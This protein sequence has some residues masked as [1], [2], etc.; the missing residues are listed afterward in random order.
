[1]E[2]FAELVEK[3]KQFAAQPIVLENAPLKADDLPMLVL[4]RRVANQ[5]AAIDCFLKQQDVEIA[6]RLPLRAVLEA[7]ADLNRAK[8]SALLKPVPTKAR[9]KASN[10][11]DPEHW[12]ILC[13]LVCA[14][15]RAYM[16]DGKN[17]PAAA[18]L[19]ARALERHGIGDP[20]G[21]PLD[22]KTIGRWDERSDLK[23]IRDRYIAVLKA[24]PPDDCEWAKP[25][26]LVDALLI[27][28]REE[29]EARAYRFKAKRKTVVR[30]KLKSPD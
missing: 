25:D 23:R 19:V 4:Q 7:V 5:L 22:D 3:L 26:A 15:M 24:D 20:Q 6:D 2:G 16:D 28:W 10:A 8:A 18:V 13:G 21:Q 30:S 9:P 1:M 12:Q 27:R 29:A 14:A 17:R 11:A